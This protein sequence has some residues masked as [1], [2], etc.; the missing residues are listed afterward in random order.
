MLMRAAFLAALSAAAPVTA[1]AA[2][3][4]PTKAAGDV[5]VSA[6]DDAAMVRREVRFADLDLNSAVGETSL[7]RRVRHAIT[8]LC[9]EA[10]AGGNDAE[11]MFA[12]MRCNKSAWRSIQPEIARAIAG[13]RLARAS[14]DNSPGGTMTVGQLGAAHSASARPASRR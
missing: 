5:T 13:A 2:P 12:M 8:D 4:G 9:S 3:E 14:G 10:A 7:R 6:T 11:A 1:S